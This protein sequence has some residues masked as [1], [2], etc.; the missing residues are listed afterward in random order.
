MRSLTEWYDCVDYSCS[1][2][3][4]YG[5]DVTTVS[6]RYSE[7]AAKRRWW[8]SKRTMDEKLMSLLLHVESTYFPSLHLR[9][10]S[11]DCIFH[12]PDCGTL[13]V[14]NLASRFEAAVEDSQPKPEDIKETLRKLTIPKLKQRLI[15]EFG[16]AEST[17]RKMK[18][19]DICIDSPSRV[20]HHWRVM[21]YVGCHRWRSSWRL[22]WKRAYKNLVKHLL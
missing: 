7:E 5:M 4:L 11:D 22:Y 1:Q 3:Q 18:K 13:P 16:F 17:F 14:G 8:E 15:D 6:E 9:T 2:N 20:C 10:G 12:V 19:Q 21:L